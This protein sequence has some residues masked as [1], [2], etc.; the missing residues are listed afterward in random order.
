MDRVQYKKKAL[1]IGTGMLAVYAIIVVLMVFAV[2][3]PKAALVEKEKYKIKEMEN[4]LK[5]YNEFDNTVSVFDNSKTDIRDVS[6][7]FKKNLFNKEEVE[8]G[9]LAELNNIT[10]QTKTKIDRL[11]PMGSVIREEKNYEKRIW[12]IVMTADFQSILSFIHSIEKSPIFMGID[13]I[14]IVSGK[15]K[16]LHEAEIA[17]YTVIPA[18][19]S[20]PGIISKYDLKN[21]TEIFKIPSATF[22]MVARIRRQKTALHIAMIMN[23][24][25]LYFGDTIFPHLKEKKVEKKEA[26]VEEQMPSI[27]L[28]AIIWDP[29]NPNVIINGEVL[30]R[31]DS[32]KGVRVVSI[33]QTSVTVVWHSQ[34]K[35]LKLN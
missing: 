19:T 22:N 31:G 17:I 16:R 4:N 13:S 18:L 26:V 2:I 25:P 21:S 27:T 29:A 20:A 15:E 35:V 24:D 34:K 8:Q 10:R 3:K 11:I 12:K 23:N 33:T 32:I 7:E 9:I 30:S 14:D 6:E 1:V 28:Q 5:E